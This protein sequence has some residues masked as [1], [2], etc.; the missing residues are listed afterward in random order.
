M[1][2][3]L[4]A[5]AI[6]LVL[7]GLA[8]LALFVFPEQLG[9]APLEPD[10]GAAASSGAEPDAPAA[11]QHPTP[12][13][14]TAPVPK[15]QGPVLA[16]LPQSGAVPA[17]KLGLPD[18]TWVEALNGVTAPAPL[19]WPNERPWSPIVGKRLG[20]GEPPVWWYVHADGSMSTTVMAWR[21]DLGREDAQTLVAN[22]AATQPVH[23][24]AP[25]K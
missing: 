12:A 11:T 14:S 23:E 22:P 1:D 24:D 5:G 2:R 8:G 13:A 16:V 7:L 10:R 17:G 20:Q 15:G 4:L 9:L 25:G 3:R 21:D 19:R 6:A 18:G